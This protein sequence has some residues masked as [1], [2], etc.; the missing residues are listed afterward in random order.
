MPLAPHLVK[1]ECFLASGAGDVVIFLLVYHSAMPKHMVRGRRQKARIEAYA[2][3]VFNFLN[4][5]NLGHSTGSV[6]VISTIFVQ[7]YVVRVSVRVFN[8]TIIATTSTTVEA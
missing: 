5:V 8:V 4:K 6:E 2:V 3:S 1:S 7:V